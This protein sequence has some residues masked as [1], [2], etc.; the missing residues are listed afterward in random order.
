LSHDPEQPEQSADSTNGEKPPIRPSLT[1][2]EVWEAADADQTAADVDQTL[3]DAEQTLSDADQGASERDQEQAD[4]DQRASERDQTAADRDWAIHAPRS[5][6]ELRDLARSY[7]DRAQGTAERLASAEKRAHNMFD[8]AEAATRRDHQA[9]LRDL[10]AA[11]RDRSAELRDRALDEYQS[12]FGHRDPEISRAR[13]AAAEDRAR[14]AQDRTRAAEDRKQAARDRAQ[15]RVQLE[16]AQLDDLTGFYRLSLGR[17]VLQR[18]IDRCRRSGRRLVLVYCDVDGLKQVNDE[19][20][21]AAGDALL[22]EVAEA[23]RS[24]LRSYDPVVR[25]GGDEFVCAISETNEDQVEGIFRSIQGSLT[26]GSEEGS[27]SFGLASMQEDDDL[28][29]LLERGDRDLRTTR[30]A[31]G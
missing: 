30:S 3:S 21:H 7:A 24:R 1:G 20:G 31:S 23:I 12:A 17:A 5:P 13:A 6:E 22:S 16:K 14:A 26:R 25:I 11:A 15:A 8:R 29:A 28:E 19:R 9:A 4:A 2:A 10:Q 18:E 27:V